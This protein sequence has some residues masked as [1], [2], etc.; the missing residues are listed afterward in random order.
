MTKPTIAPFG[1]W[2]SPITA[3]V[4]YSEV[5][6]ADFISID[7]DN[8]YWL[9]TRPQEE[10]RSVII[11]LSP[12]GPITDCTPEGFNARTRVHEY[13]GG[14]YLVD[15]DVIYFSNFKD[16]R[17]YRKEIGG[18][19]I[20]ITP[21]ENLRFAD[22]VLDQERSRLIIVREDHTVEGEPI[23]SIVSLDLNQATPGT[24]LASGYDFYSSPRISPNASQLAW[25]CWNHPNMPWDGTEL[26]VA[27]ILKDG[28]LGDMK[29]VAGGA[30]ECIFQ[31]EWSPEGILYFSSDRSGWWNLFRLKDNDIEAVTN[32]EGEFG[33]PQWVFGES[34]YG[35][36]NQ[37]KII[38]CY[39]MMGNWHLAKLDI[40]SKSLEEIKTLYSEIWMLKVGKGFSIF[41][42]SSPTEPLSVVKLDN[43]TN[44]VEALW[45]NRDVKIDNSYFSIPKPIEFPTKGNKSAHGFYYPP[46]NPNFIGPENEKPPLIVISHGGPTAATATAFRYSTQFWTSKGFALLDVNYGGSTGYGRDFRERLTGKWGI[47]DVQDCIAG[48]QYLVKQGLVDKNKLVIKGGSAGGFTTLSALT[49]YD[50]FAAGASYFG[51]SDLEALTLDTH[52]FESRYLD[53]LVG[54]YPEKATVYRERSPIH[55]IDQLSCPV[56]FFQGLEDKVVHRR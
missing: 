41:L 23:N 17:L 34:I 29:Q 5:V 20:P 56:I 53:K 15:N 38:C 18:E 25:L 1:S 28:S 12:D 14:A 24:I 52:K 33:K 55:F 31:P 51:V 46:H 7:G 35:F 11:R 3:D 43:E 8:V 49:F 37:E 2:K 32:I 44:Q 16:Q 40:S 47:V 13:G 27:D 21:S 4:S 6:G 26:W 19:P 22:G 39:N 10:G 45:K 42:G 50:T 54:P 48:A 30:E 36:E 9:E